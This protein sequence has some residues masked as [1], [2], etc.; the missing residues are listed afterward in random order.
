[1][2]D[3]DISTPIVQL[4][5]SIL[6]N[7]QV[8]LFIKR[9]DLTNRFISGNKYRKLKYNF[10]EA[11]NRSCKTLLTFGGAFSNHIHAVA[12][13]GSK[14]DFKTIGIIRGEESLPLNPTLSDANSYGMKLHYISRV[15][16][17]EK[18]E[19]SFIEKLE[20]EF[21]K[22]YLIPEGGSNS[23]AVKGCTEII[24]DVSV[25]FDHVC[26]ACG[27]GG[28]IAGI[29]SDL[30][31]KHKIWGF[32]ALKNG[33]FLMKDIKRLIFDYCNGA[34]NNWELITAYHF[35]GY[36]KYD[37]D[38]IQFI[39]R[40]K[41]KHDIQLDPIYTG[42]LFY[43]IYDMIKN[44]FFKPGEKILAIHTGGIQ[45]I[46]GFNKRFGNLIK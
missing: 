38:L 37:Y 44:G 33:E 40:F 45:G 32:P 16:Y 11:R 28:T 3:E 12:Y 26:C 31:G 14:F 22:F 13:A 2:F 43:G 29:I 19:E 39:N 36:A 18:Y 41:I 34:F 7:N 42:K 23:L 21:G 35:G 4:N 15:K 8:Q 46:R 6:R 10:I 17:R 9:E 20:T 30:D 25:S 24:K 1:M 5:D 27:T